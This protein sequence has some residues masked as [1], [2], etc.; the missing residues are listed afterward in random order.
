MQEALVRRPSIDLARGILMVAWSCTANDA[1][2]LLVAVSQHANTKLHDVAE[3][4]VT[5]VQGEPLPEHL[6]NH[7]AAA[8]ARLRAL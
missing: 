3:A 5:S 1:W 8:V 4:V 2:K 6:Q 7:L